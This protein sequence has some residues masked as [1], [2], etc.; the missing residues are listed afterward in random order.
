MLARDSDRAVPQVPAPMTAM[1]LVLL[2]AFFSSV[3][4]RLSL[5]VPE[6][7]R[8]DGGCFGF[9]QQRSPVFHN[10]IWNDLGE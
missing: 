5:P 8:R 2:M 10:Q 9:G 4:L 1:C 7:G 3:F 6:S